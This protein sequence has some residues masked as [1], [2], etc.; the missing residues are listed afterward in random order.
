MKKTLTI[1]MIL[2]LFTLVYATESIAD[3]YVPQGEVLVNTK[4]LVLNDTTRDNDTMWCTE[5]NISKH[6]GEFYSIGFDIDAINTTVAG[7]ILMRQGNE[8]GNLQFYTSLFTLSDE[9]D[10]TLDITTDVLPM[11]WLQI[12]VTDTDNTDSLEVDYLNINKTQ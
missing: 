3:R 12:G 7:E 2:L 1:G 11:T 5:L 10:T 6:P 4:T 9:V 8:K